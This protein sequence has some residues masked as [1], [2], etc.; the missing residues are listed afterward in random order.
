MA[1][2]ISSVMA[3]NVTVS[4][5][6]ELPPLPSYTIVE[7]P[8]LI[9]WFPDAYLSIVGPIAAYWLVSAFFHIIDVYDFWPQ[10]RLHTPAEI[11]SRNRATR[12]EVFRDVVLRFL[13]SSAHLVIHASTVRA[14]LGILRWS[15]RRVL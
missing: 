8:D 4:A 15:Y 3:D 5:P 6:T 14:D 11:A 2:V 13:T 10:Y 7:R 1:S 12:Y 9:S